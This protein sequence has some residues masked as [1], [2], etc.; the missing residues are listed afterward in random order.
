MIKSKAAEIIKKFSEEEKVSFQEFLLS[1]Y[2]NKKDKLTELYKLI[3]KNFDKLDE[4]N[5]TEEKIFAGLFKDKEFS[6]SFLR[7]L[8]SELYA[9]CE[10][11]LIINKI[12]NDS[13]KDINNVLALLRQYNIRFLDNHFNVKLNKY[14][15]EFKNADYDE[16]I[17][18]SLAKIHSESI[19]FDLYRS[20]MENVSL[21]LLDKSEYELCHISQLLAS[22]MNDF[23]VNQKAFNLDFE[24]EL[25]TGFIENIDIGNFLK[26]LEKSNS[27]LKDEIQIR[28][29]FILLSKDHKDS[30]N[31]FKLKDLILKKISKYTN[32][33]RFNIFIKLKNFCAVRIFESDFSFYVEKYSLSK[34]ETEYIK[35]NQ[36]G[37]GPLYAN[38]YIENIIFAVKSKDMEFAKYYIDNLTIELEESIRESLYNLVMAHLEFAYNNFEKTLEYLSKVDNFNNLIKNTSKLLY[39]KSFYEMNSLDSGLSALDSYIHFLMENKNYTSNRKKLLLF[40]YE[41]LKKIYKIKSFPQ[42][43]SEYE[44]NNLKKE[45][46][47]SDI[48]FPDWYFKKIEEL[49][50]I[51]KKPP[52]AIK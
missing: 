29:R 28:F 8:M 7:N 36:D 1:P 23:V 47:K 49:K 2:F 41:F 52:K 30:D 40:E 10:K 39:I 33:E 20:K 15:N 4:E 50:K 11:F 19:S 12:N 17:F 26:F 43:Y 46:E 5:S 51:L 32:A 37:V 25:L 24:S 6:Y 42:K 16:N 45:I 14:L 3:L 21:K 13:F 48:F 44:L 35:F 27:Q 38:V 18:Y 34:I 9:L 22:N 31:Y